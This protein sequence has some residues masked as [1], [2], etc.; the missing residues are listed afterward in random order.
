MGSQ[1]ADNPEMKTKLDTLAENIHKSAVGLTTIANKTDN[2]KEGTEN[3]VSGLDQIKGQI[4][5]STEMSEGFTGAIT[6]EELNNMADG[7]ISMGE[8]LSKLSQGL[9]SFQSKYDMM[10]V[11][12]PKEQAEINSILYE[13]DGNL[14]TMFSDVLLDDSSNLMMIKLQGNLADDKKDIVFEQV[15]A[16]FN[17]VEF[18]DVSYMISGKPVLDS[19]LRDEMKK[20]MMVMVVAAVLIMFVVLTLIFKIRWRILSLGIIFV[21]VIA[22]LGFMGHLSVPMTM[23]SMAVFPILIGLGIDYS[24]QFQN[25]YE[26]EKSVKDTLAQVGKAVGIAVLATVFGF[27]SLYAS[28]VPMIQDFGKMLTIGVIVSFIGSIFLL[29]PILSARDTLELQSKTNKKI[30]NERPTLIDRTLQ[31]STKFI[32][33]HKIV[34][35]VLSILL[36]GAGL[37]ADNKVGVETDIETFMPQDMEALSDI[38]YIRDIVGST[39]QMAIFL[40]GEALLSQ[41][42]M[43]WMN[44]TITTIEEKYPEKITGIKSI[45][46]LVSNTGDPNELSY[47]AY[48]GFTE[49]TNSLYFSHIFF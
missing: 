21:S 46:S 3:T 2:L 8:N 37:F 27:M 34:I 18:D 48:L 44:D 39:D 7:F 23:V 25:R 12:F 40:D 47:D 4:G 45:N 14:R 1:L 6:P 22:T 43:A 19:S 32:A 9:K 38:H 33:K 5:F 28:P 41:E 36:S 30:L 15:E 20:N 35:L 11:D 26:E 49:R 10:I 17:T 29:M 24:I 13:E 31:K 16:A 42:N